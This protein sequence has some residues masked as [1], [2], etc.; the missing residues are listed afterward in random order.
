MIV[1]KHVKETVMYR[2]A[3]AIG[4]P[5]REI[6]LALLTFNVGAELLNVN[7]LN[8]RQQQ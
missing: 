1:K 5:Q 7:S 8:V 4:L 2:E 3:L 6:P